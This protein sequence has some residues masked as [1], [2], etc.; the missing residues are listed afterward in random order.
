MSQ[1]TGVGSQVVGVS[2]LT[3]DFPIPR[4]EAWSRVSQAGLELALQPRMAL[5]SSSRFSL[6]S[7]GVP[8]EHPHT[9][10]MAAFPVV[11]IGY[12]DKTKSKKG[13]TLGLR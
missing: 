10:C 12:L 3:W 1:A 13:L 5:K 9:W 8:G 11:V 2:L 7:A 4:F 6:L